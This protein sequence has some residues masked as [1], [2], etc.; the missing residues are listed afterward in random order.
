MVQLYGLLILFRKNNYHTVL[1]GSVIIPWYTVSVKKAIHR[2]AAHF[3][4]VIAE[5][6]PLGLTKAYVHTNSARKQFRVVVTT[7][8]NHLVTVLVTDEEYPTR[9]SLQI[10][11]DTTE[12]LMQKYNIDKLHDEDIKDYCLSKFNKECKRILTRH[13]DP[14][15]FDEISIAKAK[16]KNI[17]KIATENIEKLL[18]RGESLEE[19]MEQAQLLEFGSNDF[20]ITSKK[21]NRCCRI[22]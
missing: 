18:Q 17:K 1:T 6:L 15:D 4:K 12:L 19:I 20:L 5:R 3:G 13:K 21:L 9:I 10:I 22:S 7:K 14:K 8:H 11:E 16:I 2:L